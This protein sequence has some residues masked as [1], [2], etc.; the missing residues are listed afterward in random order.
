MLAGRTVNVFDPQMAGGALLDL[1]VY[2]AHVLVALFGSPLT[3]TSCSIPVP[4]GAD[5]A[6][7]ALALYPGFVADLSWSKI[8]SSSSPSEIRG[9]LGSLS[10]DHVASPRALVLTGADGSVDPFAVDAESHTLVPQIERFV[11]LVRTGRTS[12]PEHGT[13]RDALRLVDR[14]R[15]QDA[16]GLR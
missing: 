8:T 3:V 13:T 14:I 12:V 15:Q 5:G 4:T 11:H 9:E 7:A 2:C 1:G 6:G 10:V 16:G